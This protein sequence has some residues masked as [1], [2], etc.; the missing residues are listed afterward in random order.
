MGTGTMFMTGT[1]TSKGAQTFTGSFSGPG[2]VEVKSR[3]IMRKVSNDKLVLE[4]F[5][6]WGA[7]EMKCMELT[8]TRSK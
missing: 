8:Y 3:Y 2:G 5:N 4:M 1:E 6:D 7:G